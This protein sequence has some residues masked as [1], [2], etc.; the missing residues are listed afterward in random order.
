MDIIINGTRIEWPEL[1]EE[2]SI[3]GEAIEVR[4]CPT[5]EKVLGMDKGPEKK[6]NF[7]RLYTYHDI[8]KLKKQM[9]QALLQEDQS[10][11]SVLISKEGPKDG[12]A[13]VW[14]S[15]IKATREAVAKLGITA[16]GVQ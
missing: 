11:N 4:F 9:W 14:V 7:E 16:E 12:V 3:V 8:L 13:S 15:G 10:G 2:V 1:C 6:G 5:P